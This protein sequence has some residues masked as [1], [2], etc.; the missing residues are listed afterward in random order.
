MEPSG[1]ALAVGLLGSGGLV[2]MGGFGVTNEM[3][4]TNQTLHGVW[5]D[6]AGRYYAVGGRSDD[7]F[8]GV[9]LVRST[10]VNG[11]DPMIPNSP[12]GA[13]QL[14]IGVA[15]GSPYAPLASNGDMP[16]FSGGQGGFHI[17]PSFHLT[18]FAP[19]ANLNLT[20]SGTMVNG[21]ATV[22]QEFTF[23]AQFE[24]IGGG[25]NEL[26]DWFVPIILLRSEVVGEQAVLSFEVW[27]V[28][29]PSARASAERTVTFMIGN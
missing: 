10:E 1:E 17:F 2:D 26:I 3:T 25:V 7:I 24:D 6:G 27:D 29:D 28:N 23:S 11:N 14:E 8:S 4:G 20:S 9:A 16:V 19:G 13:M 15:N 22:V 5:G 18:G 21:G 12:S